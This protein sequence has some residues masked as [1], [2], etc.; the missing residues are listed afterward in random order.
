M[1][2]RMRMG[3]LRESHEMRMRTASYAT[4]FD[5]KEQQ[6]RSCLEILK[7]HYF[8]SA[9]SGLEDNGMWDVCMIDVR[10]EHSR[11][12]IISI[13]A[14]LVKQRINCTRQHFFERDETVESWSWSWFEG[15]Y[16]LVILQDWRILEHVWEFVR[17]E[18]YM[19][20]LSFILQKW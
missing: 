16:F 14:A 1:T 7:S 8:V 19:I 18:Y 9:T 13:A 17:C 4:F 6:S 5:V 20:L 10:W 12:M 11:R 3:E 15:G 2:Q